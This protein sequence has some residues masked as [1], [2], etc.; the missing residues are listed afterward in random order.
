MRSIPT[1][2]PERADLGQDEPSR[3]AALS[4]KVMADHL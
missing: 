4:R 3:R 2:M 1:P